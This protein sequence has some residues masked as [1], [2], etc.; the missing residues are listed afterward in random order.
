[1]GKDSVL[2]YDVITISVNITSFRMCVY[3]FVLT[4]L[5][6][7]IFIYIYTINIKNF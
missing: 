5:H 4:Y 6:L 7:R 2:F 1:M 3:F